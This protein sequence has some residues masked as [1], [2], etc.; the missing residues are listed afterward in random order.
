MTMH[1]KGDNGGEAEPFPSRDQVSEPRV[2]GAWAEQTG[3]KL[4]DNGRGLHQAVVL[5]TRR[6]LDKP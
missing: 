2:S 5:G 3:N 6:R 4:D 1:I